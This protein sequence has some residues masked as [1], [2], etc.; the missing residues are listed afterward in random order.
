[1]SFQR[2][3]SRNEKHGLGFTLVEL[4]VVIAIIG[5]LIGMLLPA[6]QQVRESARR[7]SCLNN[8][9]QIGLGA[10]NFESAMQRF[11]TSGG[12]VEQFTNPEE[13]FGSAFGYQ[14]LGW[15]FQILPFME[16]E[17]LVS[18]RDREGINEIIEPQVQ[19]FNCP[20]RSGRFATIATEIYALPD[21][22]GVMSSHNDAGWNG[23]EYR[24]TEDPRENEESVVYTGII[25]KGG[26]V[27]VNSGQV[28][29]FGDVKFGSISDGSSNT[30]MIAEKSVRA[31]AYTIT[32]A[33]PWPFW[34]VFGYYV[35]S[36]WPNMRQFG[37]LTDVQAADREVPVRADNEVRL[38]GE[39]SEQGFGSAHPGVFNAVA[40]DGST[41]SLSNNTNLLLLDQLGKR[42]DG[43]TATFDSL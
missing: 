31:N 39:V 33:E 1:M 6:V 35:G 11:P 16:Q 38:S 4:L 42:A 20:S 3:R 32:S 24:I 34:E 36:D 43:T 21:Y 7:T 5:I 37:A 40:G 18:L 14:H 27:N 29:D 10:L 15:M 22:A 9:R 17:N 19:A 13:E 28:F 23:F 26:H 8:L 12:A 25:I 30:V 41:R 2:K